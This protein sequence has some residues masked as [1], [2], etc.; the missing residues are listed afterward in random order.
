[1]AAVQFFGRESV[2]S[3]FANR[4]IECWA[5][6]QGKHLI[7]AGE[8]YEPLNTFLQ[9]LEPGGS[10]A[11]Y[12]LKVY[13]D[14]D[15]P[16]NITDKTENNGSFTFKLSQPL[17]NLRVHNDIVLQRLEAIEQRIA[18]VKSE[19]DEDDEEEEETIGKIVMD[20]LKDPQKLSLALSAIKG[21][22]SSAVA[23]AA[24]VPAVV[25]GIGSDEEK[26]TRLS[27][28]L[29]RLESKDPK[30]IE[31]LEKLADIADKKPGTFT[32]LLQMLENGI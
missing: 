32:M 7:T 11:Q 31:H 13:R 5:L 6:F 24:P 20:Y 16:E 18:G 2:L 30:I 3:A 23:P 10:A 9:M 28:V 25:G 4:G 1:M 27:L 21:F 22:I 17:G 12:A 14:I 29:D 8:G 15:D 19:E 26:L